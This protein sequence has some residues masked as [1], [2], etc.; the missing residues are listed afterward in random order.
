MSFAQKVILITFDLLHPHDSKR[1][2]NG[3]H[4]IIKMTTRF[5]QRYNLPAPAFAAA[6]HLEHAPILKQC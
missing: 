1:E 6:P 4:Y 2:K 3:S 5:Q